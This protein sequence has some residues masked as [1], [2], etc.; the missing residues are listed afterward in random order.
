MSEMHLCRFG[1]CMPNY[2][3]LHFSCLPDEIPLPSQ[4]S[5]Y[6]LCCV[7]S[8]R[9]ELHLYPHDVLGSSW[10]N[11]SDLQLQDLL[12]LVPAAGGGLS[13]LC[14][15]LITCCIKKQVHAAPNATLGLRMV[16]L[17]GVVFLT[18]V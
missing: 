13:S 16:A 18:L 11:A 15:F 14:K 3:W 10:T 9:R 4:T 17:P 6:P 7:Q 1:S 12:L 5:E 2:L 8:C